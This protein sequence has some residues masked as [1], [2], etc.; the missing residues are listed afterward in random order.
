MLTL[1]LNQGYLC[2]MHWYCINIMD[3]LL[4]YEFW[5]MN[6]FPVRCLWGRVWTCT[7][8]QCVLHFFIWSALK[9]HWS[10]P[11]VVRCLENDSS[12]SSI[13]TT[14]SWNHLLMDFWLNLS[15]ESTLVDQLLPMASMLS[16]VTYF[17][18]T[19]IYTPS[20]FLLLQQYP[21]LLLPHFIS[22]HQSNST[23]QVSTPF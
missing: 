14:V 9:R 12:H 16:S 19:H 13:W 20:D 23:V 15:F 8:E 22:F 7:E 5:L 1:D 17:L 21:F 2:L 6:S 10:I 4:C 11:A 3:H 18:R